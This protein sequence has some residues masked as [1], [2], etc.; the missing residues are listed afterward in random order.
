VKLRLQEKSLSLSK[1]DHKSSWIEISAADPGSYTLTLSGN[2]K[3]AAPWGHAQPF[4][5]TVALEVFPVCEM[6]SNSIQR[7]NSKTAELHGELLFGK[8]ATGARFT[9]WLKGVPEVAFEQDG[10]VYLKNPPEDVDMAITNSEN[11]DTAGRRTKIE[12]TTTT[13]RAF[14]RREFVL[15]LIS[16]VDKTPEQWKGILKQI[17]ME[18]PK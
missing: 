4:E 18:P 15:R 13:T 9:L 7:I 5:Q 12:W 6:L 1:Y 8:A 3:G 14:T 2:A 11:L 16:S 10:V 17:D